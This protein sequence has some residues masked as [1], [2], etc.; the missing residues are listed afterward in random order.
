MAK[1]CRQ[2]QHEHGQ[3]AQPLGGVQ[4]VLHL[5]RRHDIRFYCH[6]FAVVERLGGILCQETVPYGLIQALLQQAV[7]VPH[8]FFAQTRAAGSM[9]AEAPPLLQ[10]FS[11][12]LRCQ[13]RERYISQAG[14]NVVFEHI[15][16]CRIGGRSALVP[17]IGFLPVGDVLS[18]RHIPTSMHWRCRSRKATHGSLACFRIFLCK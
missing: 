9:I 10:K 13:F 6:G 5:Q 1:P 8:G 11:D 16:V 17:V 2:R 12:H 7:D 18:E 15:V 14:E 3:I 4:I